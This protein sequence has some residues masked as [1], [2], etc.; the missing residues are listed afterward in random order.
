MHCIC[1]ANNM[2][3]REGYVT[4]AEFCLDCWNLINETNDKPYKYVLSKEEDICEECGYF[5]QVVIA[6]RKF[7]LFQ[8]I[9]YDRK[10]RRQSKKD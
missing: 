4:M 1:N 3:G 2:P 6:R 5:T 10:Q 7:Y 9:T 8:K